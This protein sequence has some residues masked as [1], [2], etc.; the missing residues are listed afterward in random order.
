MCICLFI[1]AKLWKFYSL[2]LWRDQLPLGSRNQSTPIWQMD[3]SIRKFRRR[4]L[5]WLC[6]SGPGNFIIPL[7]PLQLCF[8]LFLFHPFYLPSKLLIFIV[9]S[10]F[11][12]VIWW[13]LNLSLLNSKWVCFVF[14]YRLLN[15]LEGYYSVFGS[16]E[17]WAW[18]LSLSFVDCTEFSNENVVGVRSIRFIYL[19]IFIIM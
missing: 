19:F 9:W 17:D 1:Y 18:V 7:H 2:S 11:Q 16:M 15:C 10:Q 14:W 8:C 3:R 13:N 5:S 12:I 4:L 6:R